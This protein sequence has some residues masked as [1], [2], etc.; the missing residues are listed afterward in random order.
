MGGIKPW[1]TSVGNM[2]GGKARIGNSGGRKDLMRVSRTVKNG[3]PS[4]S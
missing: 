3:G 4:D 2:E 1:S